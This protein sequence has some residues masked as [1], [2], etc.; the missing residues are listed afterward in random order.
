M[1]GEETLG[2]GT[3]F[4][5][6]ENPPEPVYN[7]GDLQHLTYELLKRGISGKVIAGVLGGNWL[8]VLRAVIG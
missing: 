1:A 3:D 5:S 4:D 6:F 8:R 2:L 7:I